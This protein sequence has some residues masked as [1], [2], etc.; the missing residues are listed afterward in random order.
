MDKKTVKLQIWD[1]AGQVSAHLL[2]VGVYFH[3]YKAHKYVTTT[4]NTNITINKQLMIK[5]INKLGTIPN[6]HISI[7][8]RS[9]WNYYGL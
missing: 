8:P 5:T 4:N 3:I 7:L 1:T 9:R 2:S 6:N